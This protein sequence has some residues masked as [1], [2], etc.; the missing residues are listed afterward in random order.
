MTH[1]LLQRQLKKL[2]IDPSTPPDKVAWQELQDQISNSY[3]EADED[4][5]L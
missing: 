2:G 5:P 3:T 4:R 1:H